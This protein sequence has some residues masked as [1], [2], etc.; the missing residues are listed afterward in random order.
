MVNMLKILVAVTAL[1]T[2]IGIAL[3]G[4]NLTRAYLFNSA[5]VKNT[6]GLWLE[7]ITASLVVIIAIAHYLRN[8]PEATIA[9]LIGTFIFFAGGLLQLIARKQLYED[10]T[11]EERLSSGFEAAQTGLYAHIRYPSKSA[12]LLLLTGLCVTLGS[13]WSLGLLYLLFFP[14]AL[15]RISQ[16]EQTLLDKFGNRWLSYKEDTKRIIPYF[17]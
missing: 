17:I 16:E 8:K 15:Y 13:W 4:K 2:I 5:R 7:A 10:K 12:M 6:E 14:S 11:F 9:M 1:Q 3:L